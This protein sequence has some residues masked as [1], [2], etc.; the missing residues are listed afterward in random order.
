MRYDNA[1]DDRGFRTNEA[2]ATS[3]TSRVLA[4]VGAGQGM[5]L[6]M[7]VLSSV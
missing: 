3:L 1:I 4:H 5:L 2:E 6:S 7:E